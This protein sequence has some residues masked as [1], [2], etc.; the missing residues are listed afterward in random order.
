MFNSLRDQY[1]DEM[2]VK[3]EKI[4]ELA[5]QEEEKEKERQERLAQM[6]DAKRKLLESVNEDMPVQDMPDCMIKYRKIL[7]EAKGPGK[8]VFEDSKFGHNEQALG[9]GCLN[10]GVAKWMRARDVPGAKLYMDGA[11]HL[12]VV[13]GA[14]GDCYFLSAI[15]VLGSQRVKDIIVIE[16]TEEEWRECGAFCV[17]FYKGGY[18]EIIIIDDYFP[19]YPNGQWAFVKGG[20]EGLELW[21]MVLEKAYAKMYGSYNFIEAGK[22]Q[23]ALAD[24]TDGFPQQLDLRKDAKNLP[25]FW[26]KL[27]TFKKHGALMGAGSP[28]NAMGDRAINELGIVQG[29]AYAILDVVEIDGYKLLQMRNPH[30]TRGV[31]WEGDWG[32]DSEKW[33]QRYKQKL[34]Y[35]NKNDGVFWI[36]VDDFIEQFSYI[37]VCQILDEKDGWKEIRISDEWKGESAEGLPTRNNPKAKLDKNPQ[38]EITVQRPCDGFLYLQQMDTINMFKGKHNIFF[39]VSK[40]K[41][42][43]I[44]R[45]D[46]TK[47]VCMSGAPTNLNIVTSECDFDR[48]VSYPYKFTLMV[49]N[50]ENG[51]EGEGKFEL[52]VYAMDDRTQVRRI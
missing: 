24:M 5:R 22:V 50:A 13:Q 10:R 45:V 46:K 7:K 48:T 6:S 38:F 21:P 26:E 29:H 51:A 12:D 25:V 15:S 44:T 17:R 30:G 4:K 49:A 39:M 32:D 18:E 40:E 41:G 23:Y 3:E 34:N 31:E 14:L 9:P 37:Y 19:A 52:G 2:R 8:V 42:G 28:E 1:I 16:E 43:K 33:S 20:E 36:E 11:S 27:K 47:M 35:E